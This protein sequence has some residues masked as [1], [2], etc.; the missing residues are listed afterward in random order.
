[1][2]SRKKICQKIPRGKPL[3]HDKMKSIIEEYTS[4]KIEDKKLFKEK[5]IPKPEK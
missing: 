2:F 1:M 3:R 5:S 4:K